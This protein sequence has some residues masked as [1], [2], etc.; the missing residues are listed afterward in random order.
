MPCPSAPPAPSPPALLEAGGRNQEGREQRRER[1][2]GR[3]GMR[4][5]ARWNDS[6]EDNEGCTCTCIYHKEEGL[7]FAAKLATALPV[8]VEQLVSRDPGAGHPLPACQNP[9]HNIWDGL[10]GLVR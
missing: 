10:L 9:H 1:G 3:R 4:G 6:R 8:S 5:R 7:D 2:G